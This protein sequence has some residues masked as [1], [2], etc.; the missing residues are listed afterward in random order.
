LPITLATLTAPAQLYT[1]KLRGGKPQQLTR[2]NADKLADVRF[3]E[4]E[5]FSFKGANGDTVYGHVMKPW[6]AVPGAK[7][8]IAFLVHGGP[9]GSFGN[10][11][12]YRWNPQVYAGAGY[13][14][15]FID[16]HGSTGYGQKFTDA[17]SGD[18]G[19]KPL[20]DLQKGLEAAVE[21]IPLARPRAQL[22]TG[23]L[24]W[25]LHDELDRG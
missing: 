12:S 19:G 1:T 23:R 24:V 25:R 3:G 20:V 14:T 9:Q 13:A 16:F 8:P 4:F 6:N 18:W 2:N 22:R 7:Y 17:I 10:A 5:Q 21:E 11:W 15:V